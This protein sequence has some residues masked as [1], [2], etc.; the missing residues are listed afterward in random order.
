MTL[1]EYI[2]R[3]NLIVSFDSK[4]GDLIVVYSIDDE[5]NGFNRVG[6]DPAIGQYEDGDFVSAEQAK[7]SPGDWGEVV[8]NS[9]CIN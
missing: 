9:V 1:N 2:E 3:L 4:A 7:E 5:G 8:V 6:C